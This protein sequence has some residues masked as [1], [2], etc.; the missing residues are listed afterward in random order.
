MATKE[1][2]R[3][4]VPPPPTT[5]KQEESFREAQEERRQSEAP[6]SQ[7]REAL[8]NARAWLDEVEEALDGPA[9]NGVETSSETR[10]SLSWDGTTLYFG[11]NRAGSEGDADHYV[12]ARKKVTGTDG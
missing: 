11:S 1:E 8:A 9:V 5:R 12:T 10:P 3:E 6:E 2:K 7:A 4:R